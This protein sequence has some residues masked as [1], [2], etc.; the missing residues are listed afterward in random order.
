MKEK[1]KTVREIFDKYKYDRSAWSKS[2]SWF[3]QQILLLRKE[4]VTPKQLLTRN[5]QEVKQRITP[6]HLYMFIYDAKWK[7]ELPYWDAFPLVFPF[8]KTPNGFLGLNLHYLPYPLRV[9][10]LDRLMS[11]MTNQKM[12][13][14]TR[15]RLSWAI[16]EATSRLKLAK[17]CVKEYLSSNV[18]SSFRRIDVN[19]WTTAMMLP[20][21]Q[22][23]KA[24]TSKVWA[25][26]RK[27]SR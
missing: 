16:I 4:R 9:L 20:V 19:D 1:T 14:T 17:P 25:D 7:D 5:P 10:L 2:R 6:G 13:Q 27:A 21:E 26:S 22:F 18:Q 8:R 11:Y 12:D 15:L 3:T 23:Q 24:S